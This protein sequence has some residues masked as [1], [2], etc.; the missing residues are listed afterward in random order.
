ML[1]VGYKFTCLTRTITH[2]PSSPALANIHTHALHFPATVGIAGHAFSLRVL[3]SRFAAQTLAS[4]KTTTSARLARHS[5][6]FG[7]CLRPTLPRSGLLCWGTTTMC[8]WITMSTFFRRLTRSSLGRFRAWCSQN[9]LGARHVKVIRMACLVRVVLPFILCSTGTP[10]G[11]M[12]APP[13]G[14]RS[15]AVCF[16]RHVGANSLLCG[17]LSQVP[18]AIIRSERYKSACR[19]YRFQLGRF[20]LTVPVSIALSKQTYWSGRGRRERDYQSSNDPGA[21]AA[22]GAVVSGYLGTLRWQGHQSGERRQVPRY[23]LPEVRYPFFYFRVACSVWA[24][25]RARVY[26]MVSLCTTQL[27][28]SGG[29]GWASSRSSRM[30]RTW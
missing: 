5:L 11:I 25:R 15:A 7:S 19:R 18:G 12:S 26:D 2:A 6:A 22:A 20:T 27:R 3:V 4:L 24:M 10:K 28:S 1:L 9:S 23:R 29:D 14:F 16:L 17:V 21:V 8:S 30:G 13:Q